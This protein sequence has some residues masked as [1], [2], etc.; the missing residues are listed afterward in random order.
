MGGRDGRE[1]S[2]CTRPRLSSLT[3]LKLSAA[4]L[5]DEEIREEIR[6]GRLDRQNL[7]KERQQILLYNAD[8]ISSLFGY[9]KAHC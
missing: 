8:A 5:W 6:L 1:C 2:D 4:R 9:I 7:C 3:G